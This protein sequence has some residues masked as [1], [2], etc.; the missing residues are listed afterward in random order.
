MWS[1][2]IPFDICTDCSD[3]FGQSHGKVKHLA[4]PSFPA[5]SETITR[6]TFLDYPGRRETDSYKYSV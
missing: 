6:H 1:F 2:H 3:C 4:H 5:V